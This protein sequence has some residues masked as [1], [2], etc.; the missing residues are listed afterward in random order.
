VGPYNTCFLSLSEYAIISPTPFFPLSLSYFYLPSFPCSPF[1]FLSF[2]YPIFSLLL[3][4]PPLPSSHL[5]PFHTFIS[6]LLFSHTTFP[7]SFVH[8]VITSCPLSSAL[9][10]RLKQHNLSNSKSNYFLCFSNFHALCKHKHA[11]NCLL[12]TRL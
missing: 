5:Y 4:F 10:F 1:P 8:T 6:F 2:V 9:S 12:C 7:F 11:S 3:V